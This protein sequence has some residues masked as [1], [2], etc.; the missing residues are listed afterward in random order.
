MATTP[1]NLPIAP[2]QA[3]RPSKT[4]ILILVAVVIGFFVVT[5][6]HDP[7]KEAQTISAP[8]APAAE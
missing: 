5:L 1:D 8:A 2:T 4:I 3:S 6:T 7:A